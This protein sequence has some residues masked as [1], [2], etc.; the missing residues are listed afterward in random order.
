MYNICIHYIYIIYRYVY[1]V[2]WSLVHSKT[3][4]YSPF[5][6]LPKDVV[7]DQSWIFDHVLGT[8]SHQNSKIPSNFLGWIPSSRTPCKTGKCHSEGCKNFPYFPSIWLT[9]RKRDHN[10]SSGKWKGTE[11]P[12]DVI[13]Y[14]GC[15]PERKWICSIYIH[16]YIHTIHT[17]IVYVFHVYIHIARDPPSDWNSHLLWSLFW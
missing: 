15:P 2:H 3:R 8:S 4:L 13:Q 11:V 9:T 5:S 16:T 6:F 12:E 1:F 10:L 17:C 14:C 7:H